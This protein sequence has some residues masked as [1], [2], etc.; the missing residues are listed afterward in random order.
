M[1][2]YPTCQSKQQK[3]RATKENLDLRSVNSVHDTANHSRKDPSDQKQQAPTLDATHG[4]ACLS[5]KA[6][7]L[8]TRE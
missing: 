1:L 6:V 8:S 4:S 3:K 7:I 2:L 5:T